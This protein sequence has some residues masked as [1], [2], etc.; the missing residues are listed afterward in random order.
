MKLLTLN[1]WNYQ[2]N[3][4]AR[5]RM[6][7][8]LITSL[9]PD[10]VLLQET[11]H[12]FRYARGVGQAEQI[13]RLTH[14]QVTGAVAQVYVPVLRVDEGLA[15]LTRLAPL[16][17]EVRGLQLLPDE[18]ADENR[19]ICLA[20]ELEINGLRICLFNT[21]FSLSPQARVSNAHDVLAFV[22]EFAGDLP[23]FLMGDLNA[24]PYEQA[25]RDLLSEDTGWIDCWAFSQPRELGFTYPSWGPVRR[26]DYLLARNVDLRHLHVQIAGENRVDG[27]FASDHLGILTEYSP[28]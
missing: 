27:N 6:I 24:E 9:A 23:S 1:L 16:R 5:R 10:A 18:R 7:T 15:S 22:A 21:H 8:D 13:G 4:P 17:S 26:I 25:I 2:G 28:S 14:F 20:L 12:D 3:W 19:R 11:R